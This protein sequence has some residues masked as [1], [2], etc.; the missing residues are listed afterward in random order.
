LVEA[1]G[2]ARM[3]GF[4]GAAGLSPS[5]VER[6]VDRLSTRLG[7]RPWG[8]NLIHSPQEPALE[9]RIAALYLRRGVRLISA[10]AYLGLT[11]PLVRYRV[12][13]IK[14]DP[15]GEV[16]TTTRVI[17]KVS[18]VE[19]ARQFMSPPPAEML[20]ELVRRGE[21]SQTQ[22]SLAARMPLAQDI[23]VEAD[24]G[25]HTDNAA[26]PA[27]MP[28]ML[29]LRDQ[30]VARQHYELPLRVGAAGGISTPHAAAA[31][32][33]MGAAYVVTGSINQGCLEAGTSDA[34]REL[35]ATT[36]QGDVAMA[37]AADMFEAGV[38]LQVL[39]RGSLFAMRARK[40]Y[41][42][43]SRYESLEQIP[44]HELQA[45]E[46]SLFRAPVKQI[47]QQTERFWA[48]LDPA[49][50]ERAE[51]DEKHR[52]ALLFRWYL[53]KSSRWAIAGEPSRATDYQIWCGPAMA[54]FNDWVRGSH[55]EPWQNRRVVPIAMNILYGAAVLGR[56]RCLRQ[57]G[58]ELPFAQLDLSAKD[59]AQLEE[60]LS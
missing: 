10:S 37:P 16:T 4:F 12:A 8:C 40:L 6:A 21:I 27:L 19:V 50:L 35:L 54:A 30:I 59:P 18:R 29:T 57:Q 48:E 47:W 14:V 46:R 7:D 13:G 41:E 3:L 55:F 24:S 31:A 58:V 11:L 42:L 52:M 60:Y 15:A 33:A 39:K 17:A 22:A 44:P 1:M 20:A 49:Q 23:T 53:G 32:F 5:E 56:A 43:Y 45:L 26:A 25:G 51:R 36:Q 38:E 28:T 34:V 9:E 2:Q